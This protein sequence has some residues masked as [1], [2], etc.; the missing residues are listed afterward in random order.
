[1]PSRT[2]CS[3]CYIYAPGLANGL[4]QG[5][6]SQKLSAG[7]KVKGRW[8]NAVSGRRRHRE[9]EAEH[10]LF[11]SRPARIATISRWAFLGDYEWDYG[12][13][14]P[15]GR[16]S[17]NGAPSRALPIGINNKVVYVEYVERFPSLLTAAAEFLPVASLPFYHSR[18]ALIL[19]AKYFSWTCPTCASQQKA[20][21]TATIALR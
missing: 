11:H 2:H 12:L 7:I 15:V 6:T 21:T 5:K 14:S 20:P 13:E 19:S 8:L 10:C 17:L 1:M 9:T 16:W 18:Y 4:L 3:L